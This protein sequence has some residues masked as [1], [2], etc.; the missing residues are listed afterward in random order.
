MEYFFP[1]DWMNPLF[2]FAHNSQRFLQLGCLTFDSEGKIDKVLA[3][4]KMTYSLMQLK[5]FSLVLKIKK[6]KQKQ[7]KNNHDLYR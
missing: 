1:R 7:I 2:V 6:T 5:K 3:E 4:Q